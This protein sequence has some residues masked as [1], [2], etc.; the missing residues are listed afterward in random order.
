[1][2]TPES[3]SLGLQAFLTHY[4]SVLASHDWLVLYVTPCELFCL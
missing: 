4:V 3:F 2:D 1:M